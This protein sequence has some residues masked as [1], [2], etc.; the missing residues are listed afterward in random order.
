[1]P[2][3]NILRSKHN[4]HQFVHKIFK[5]IFLNG[6]V[7]ILIKVSQD[8]VPKCPINNILALGQIMACHQPGDKALS[9]TMMVS[10]LTLI[11][12]IRL[13]W[14]NT[15]YILLPYSIDIVLT[16]SICQ[17]KFELCSMFVIAVLHKT[18]FYCGIPVLLIVIIKNHMCLT[19]SII[20]FIETSLIMSR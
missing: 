13:Q 20:V 5:C 8:F 19:L 18:Q 16:P 2:S 7:W 10:I 17:S 4:G 3:C 9:E 15:K 1:M 11:C 12:I 14:V 6:S